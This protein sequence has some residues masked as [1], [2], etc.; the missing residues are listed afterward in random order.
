M[1]QERSVV[2]ATRAGDG[3]AVSLGRLVGVGTG[4]GD[5]DLVTVRAADAL[6]AADVVFVLVAGP[7]ETGTAERVV[8]HHVE[9]WRVEP[10]LLRGRGRPG[11]GWD[12]ATARIGD[13][14]LRHPGGTAVLATFGDPGIGS[15]FGRL[16][17]AVCRTVGP[18][19]IDIVPGLCPMQDVP[20]LT[21]RPLVGASGTPAVLPGAAAGQGGRR[22]AAALRD[23]DTVVATKAGPWWS[24]ILAVIER[25]GRL[26]GAVVRVAAG[27]VRPAREVPA[28]RC[29][30]L[31]TVVVPACE[32]GEPC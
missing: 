11:Q 23:F 17:E 29:P 30:Y 3:T 6:A 20:P 13:W 28:H 7:D 32:V 22:L 8:L 10:L 16:A 26:D 15:H 19:E 18:V 14:F 31:A 4:P 9:A 2:S 21:A 27:A 5:P 25:A 1:A 12:G 24:E